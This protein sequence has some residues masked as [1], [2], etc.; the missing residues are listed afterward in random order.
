MHA[1]TERLRLPEP[2]A[3]DPRMVADLGNTIDFLHRVRALKIRGAKGYV[4]TSNIVWNTLSYSLHCCKNLLALWISD[5]DVSKVHGLST[6][7][8]TLRRL[9]VHYSMNNIKDL[10]VEDVPLVPFSEMQH[11]ECLEEVD[12]SFNELKDIDESIQL[13]G[14]V[15]RLNI[16]HNN[17]TEIGCYLQLLTSL[18]ELDLSS[19]GISSILQWNELLGN[20]KK[21]ILSNNAIRDVSGLS[22]LY[23]LEYLDLQNNAL[24]TI[25]SVYP[26]GLLPCLEAL[27]L[28]G[29]P[30]RN[31]IEYRTKVL[32]AFG[33]RSCE[34]RLDG[35]APDDR[36]RDTIKL[37][38][39]L[40]R[41]KKEKEEKERK[42]RQKIEEKIRCV[43]V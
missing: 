8:R 7:K 10:L 38:L 17:V 41:A 9:I 23:S 24:E 21:L 16:S 12:F 2:T 31:V 19:N 20:L 39:A 32:E 26:L 28:C 33:E 40:R 18:T 13:L 5:S 22:R 30:V 37:R 35:K 42:R 14:G 4:G 34:I 29:N 15:Q 3:P 6:T 11:W 25:E 36:E 27:H 43:S 1:I